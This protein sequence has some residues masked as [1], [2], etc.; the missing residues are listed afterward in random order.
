MDGFDGNVVALSPSVAVPVE[1][2]DWRNQPVPDALVGFCSGCGHTPD[3]VHGV[4][5]G[6]GV[7]TLPG[8]DL[9]QGIADFYVV[10]PDLE[11]GYD[12]PEWFPSTQPMVMRLGPGLPHRGVVVDHNG[13]PV[14]GAAVGISTVH[15]GPWT[16]TLPDGTFEVSGLDNRTD[17]HVLHDERKVI[18][19]C[20]GTEGLRLQLPKPAARETV[21]VELPDEIYEV[22]E[23]RKEQRQ[24]LRKKREAAW[25]KVLVRTVG[26]PEDG[27][28][29]LCTKLKRFDLGDLNLLGKPV[30]IPDEPF[31]FELSGDHRSERYFEGD[32]AQALRDGVVRL[33]WF[34]DTIVEGR[35]VGEDGEPICGVARIEPLHRRRGGRET[36]AEVD[37]E[38][39][40]SLPVGAEGMY[41]L[42]IR[43]RYTGATREMPIELPPRGDDVVVDIGTVVIKDRS[44]LTVMAPNGKPMQKGD[45]NLHRVGFRG[46]QFENV[47]DQ[48]WGPDLQEG[49]Y[50]E[51]AAKLESP[52]GLGV[53]RVVD[54]SSRFKIEGQGPWTLQQYAGEMLL[55]IDAGGVRVGVTIRAHFVSLDGPTLLRGL[56]PGIHKAFISGAGRQ[57]AIVDIE[58]P[59]PGKG[60]A[61][62]KMKLPPVE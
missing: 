1:V 17:L 35:I 4:T 45:V 14:A 36:I 10:H 44:Q 38:G 30:P 3:L 58:V 47:N 62:L 34:E 11:L 2:R 60:R 54:A 31:V 37:T 49:D 55:D 20:N 57:S 43:E 16:R 29:T 50:V 56:E 6:N 5:N 27:S 48:W 52:M 32:R 12:S 59:A 51:L 41:L 21:V 18:F 22:I 19:A 7:V 24:E 46:W 53:D 61:I 39:G 9:L 23:L 40:V 26:M 33:H 15:R 8:V 28:V 42:V 25:L 13:I